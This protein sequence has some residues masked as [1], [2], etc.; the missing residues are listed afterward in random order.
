VDNVQDFIK[1]FMALFFEA[2]PFIVLGAL[3][4]GILEEMVPQ[5]LIARFVPRNPL[6]AIAMGGLLGLIFPMC[7][8]GI[9]PIMRRL[10]KKGLP[11]SCCIAYMLAGPII[12]AVVIL[13]TIMAFKDHYAN[14]GYA[15]IG[16]R[17]IIGYLV[18]CGTAI[19]VHRMHKKYG[20]DLLTLMS[21]PDE[22]KPSD[23]SLKV[24]ETD[25]NLQTEKPKRAAIQRLGNIAEAALHDF[26]DITVFLTI[27]AALAAGVKQFIST[28][29]IADWSG[30]YPA[31]AILVLMGLAIVVTLCSEADAFVAASFT[32][33]HPS[34]KLAFLV[35]GPMLDFKL[36][37]MYTRVFRGRLIRTII[38]C[39]IVQV[40]VWTMV[41][42]Y[43]W[44]PVIKKA[45]KPFV[46]WLHPPEKYGEKPTSP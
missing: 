8:C 32:T 46:N 17:V 30:Q 28:K 19:I 39:L 20:N 34:A 40:F 18:A 13:S 21:R 37:L 2:M 36:I 38:P 42:H 45:E 41:A 23:K 10:L 26:V 12:N 27:G 1:D 31:V 16:L 6:L 14:G 5:Q 7:E 24:L 25:A 33:L 35:L 3:I 4:S 9:V 29:D 15:I 44:E 22:P 11:L 43:L